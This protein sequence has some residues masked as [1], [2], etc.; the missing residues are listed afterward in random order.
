MEGKIPR[1]EVDLQGGKGRPE[2]FDNL[3]HRRAP[4]ASRS[5]HSTPF[6][7]RRDTPARMQARKGTTPEE[8]R[9]NGRRPRKY[10]GRA[11]KKAGTQWK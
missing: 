6:Q 10:G 8:K 5:C 3:L 1:S 9:S 2:A 4:Y 11:D 7:N